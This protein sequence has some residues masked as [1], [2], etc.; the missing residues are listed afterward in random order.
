M[1][2]MPIVASDRRRHPRMA[3]RLAKGA[4]A[5]SLVII[6][7]G[8]AGIAL[9]TAASKRGLL[10]HFSQ[11]LVVVEGDD[12]I[13]GGRLGRYAITSDSTA[14]TFMTAVRDNPHPELAALAD[15]PV[16][17]AVTAHEGALGVPLVELG[18]F[19]RATGERLGDIV[20]SHGGQVLTGHQALGAHRT[21]DGLWSV[22]L[23]RRADGHEFEQPACGVVIA[24]GGD[25]PIG[26]LTDQVVAGE[27][28]VDLAGDRL[29]QSDDVLRLGGYEAIVERLSGKRAPRIAVVGGSTSALTTI[30]LLLRATPAL[31]LGTGAIT[32]LHRRP[33]RPFYPSAGAAL[34]EGFTEF[35]PN[36]IC[37]VSGFIYRLAG[38]RLEA[39]ELVQRMLRIDGRVPEPRLALHRITGDDAAARAHLRSADLVI[40]ALGYRPCA[41]P[42][43]DADGARVTLA[44]D[45]GRAMVDRHCRV[46]DSVGA[47]LPG[48]YGIGLAAGFVPWG[49][50]GGEASFIGQANGLWLW[51]NDV[52]MMIVDQLLG[53]RARAAA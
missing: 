2:H 52:G 15:H 34:A 12:A 4:D 32:L 6:G 42:V 24:T 3:A 53:E 19:L 5:A 51:Q 23:R 9:L 20:R 39:R 36:D 16:G 33:L 26:R 38:F 48:L 18:P 37:P 11:G 29:I 13:G 49:A 46:V 25:Q 31:P 47:A 22:R 10:P 8:P 27:R 1:L 45:A 21:R 40:A 44:A 14:Q 17:R 7:G 50:L 43:F 35:G 28:L 30:A 41:L